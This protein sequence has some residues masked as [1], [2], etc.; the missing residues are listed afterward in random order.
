MWALFHQQ[1]GTE[2]RVTVEYPSD[3]NLVD[4][5]AELDVLSAMAGSGFPPAVL[6]AKRSAIVS[7]EF[8][9]CDHETMARLQ[10]AVLEQ[11]QE[12]A[13]P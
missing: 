12:G 10:A 7:A 1:L 6:S 3:F 9:G 11:T 8:D 13:M 5:L 4:S 2:N